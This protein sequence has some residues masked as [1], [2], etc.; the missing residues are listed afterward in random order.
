MNLLNKIPFA[1][2]GTCISNKKNLPDTPTQLKK[3]A[4]N[5]FR[6]STTG[7]LAAKWID[8]EEVLLLSNCHGPNN[9]AISRKQKDE[10]KIETLCPEAI[11]FYNDRL[12]A[13]VLSDQLVGTYDRKSGKW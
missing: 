4:E 13:V 10:T 6:C 9:A 3:T 8:I 12:R 5:E 1:T 2:L 7:L 11:S